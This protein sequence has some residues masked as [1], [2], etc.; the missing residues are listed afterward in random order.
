MKNNYWL[1]KE[2][3]DSEIQK[4]VVSNSS[5]S[6]CYILWNNVSHLHNASL[7][8]WL[9]ACEQRLLWPALKHSSSSWSQEE[10]GPCCWHVEKNCV[11][12]AAK[13]NPL[14]MHFQRMRTL[15]RIDMEQPTPS[16]L[17]ESLRIQV[18]KHLDWNSD[19]I[20]GISSRLITTDWAI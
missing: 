7:C 5:L 12:C 4:R 9:A 8:S 16:L 2:R 6:S 11:F 15:A 18:R 3:I 14:C 13:A 1:L 20:R 10:F 19:M 17:F